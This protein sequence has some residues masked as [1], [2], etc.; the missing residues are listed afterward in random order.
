[1]EKRQVI[2]S[3]F[4]NLQNQRDLKT[5]KEISKNLNTPFFCFRSLNTG[6]GDIIYLLVKT[7]EKQIENALFVGQQSCLIT[8]VVADLLCSYLENKDLTKV[9]NTLDN[10]EKMLKGETY[11]LVECPKMEVFADITKFPQRLECIGLVIR[12]FRDI[13]KL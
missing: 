11:Q 13:L 9:K 8:V 6:C 3:Y 7:K 10:L 4:Q 12:G 5:L 1:M 2:L